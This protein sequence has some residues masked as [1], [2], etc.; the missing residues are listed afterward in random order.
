MKMFKILK[1]Y[2]VWK[3]EGCVALPVMKTVFD[4]YLLEYRAHIEVSTKPAE[5][6]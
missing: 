1:R 4:A 6:V 3:M 5:K 2:V